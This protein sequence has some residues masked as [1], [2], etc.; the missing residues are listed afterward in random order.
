MNEGVVTR[1]EADALVTQ[2]RDKLER[3]ES[4]S[5]PAASNFKQAF[6]VNWS[7]FQGGDVWDET[8]TRLPP[9]KLHFLG[10]R[11][12]TLH[13]EIELHLGCRKS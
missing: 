3:G 4:L 11:I 10:D 6:A 8:E 1:D 9:E 13:H 5:P 7:R 2:S 12:T